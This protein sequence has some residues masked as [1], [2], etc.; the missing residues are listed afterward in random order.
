VTLTDVQVPNDGLFIVGSHA[1]DLGTGFWHYEFAVYNQNSDRNGGAFTVFVPAG[2][3]LQNVGFHDVPYHDGDG[4]G[5]VNTTGTDWP[6]AIGATSISWACDTEATSASANALRWSSTYNFRFDA[7]VGPVNGTVRLG[8]WKAGAPSELDVAAQ[9]P[10][11]GGASGQAFCFGDGS[12]SACPCGNASAVGS[13]SGCLN[14]SAQ[15]AKL[16]AS[17]IASIANDTFVLQGSGM[18][19]TSPVLY[20]Q[21]TSRQNAGAGDPFGDGLRCAG[22]SL[23]RLQIEINVA[24]ASQH[25]ALGDPPIH[26]SGLTSAGDVR[27]YQGWHRDVLSFC[28]TSPFNLTNGW[29]AT[30]AP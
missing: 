26:V 19:V 24:G 10:N 6:A 22:G 4:P 25:P 21:G 18:P 28:T 14:T 13:D 17:G 2:V 12:G 8:L 30:W 23:V 20:F 5:N 15:G 9:V 11:V 29:E 1:T 3:T 16:V 7:D 27:T